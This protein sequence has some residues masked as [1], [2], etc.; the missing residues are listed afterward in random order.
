M[1]ILAI[2][3]V[4]SMLS[5]A[6]S[7][8]EEIYQSETEA[9]MNQSSLIMDLIDT[10][11]KRAGLTTKD[12]NGVLCMGGPGSFTGL[13]IGYS[14]AKGLSLSL[15][16]PFA[17]IPSLDCIAFEFTECLLLSVLQIS[18]N[19]YFYAIY[20]NGIRITDIKD[21]SF[22]QLY[23]DIIN[24]K[25]QNMKIITLTG[26]GSP[27]L[28]DFLKPRL[29]DQINH[30]YIKKGYSRELITIAKNK[31]ILHNDCTEYLIS[32]PDYIRNSV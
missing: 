20:Q 30:K 23:L 10:Q 7:S 4:S 31:N 12:L 18:K 15:D 13:R 32:G 26:P 27:I 21:A 1:N 9:D 28:Y 22:E 11:V 29:K 2:D 8:N 19:S 25:I 14:I 16:I 17:P 3:C 24:L 5:V 6:V